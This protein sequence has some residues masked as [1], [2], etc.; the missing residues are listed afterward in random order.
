MD[1]LSQIKLEADTHDRKKRTRLYKAPRSPARVK[2]SGMH[3]FPGL[4]DASLGEINKGLVAVCWD[5][6]CEVGR[7]TEYC[8]NQDKFRVV[9]KSRQTGK[10]Q[11]FILEGHLVVDAIRIARLLHGGKLQ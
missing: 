4:P 3:T 11:D 2:G 1:E 5:I 10:A 9:G 7:K 8:S 6:G